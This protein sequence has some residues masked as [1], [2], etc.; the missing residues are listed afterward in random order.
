MIKK[1]FIN[2]ILEMFKRK[3]E[4]DFSNGV[5]CSLKVNGYSLCGKEQS[6]SM[7]SLISIGRS[8]NGIRANAYSIELN[9]RKNKRVA[10]LIDDERYFSS[11]GIG[12]NS[13]QILAMLKKL[14]NEIYSIV[15]VF[16]PNTDYLTDEI[17][18][19]AQSMIA[20]YNVVHIAIYAQD[21]PVIE[22]QPYL[23]RGFNVLLVNGVEFYDCREKN[24]ILHS[25]TGASI[26]TNLRYP[27]K[28]KLNSEWIDG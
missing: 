7:A 15:T 3:E 22:A 12:L 10:Y 6:F 4:Y 24:S 20:R 28:E 16:L 5:E 1:L 2:P 23:S 13:E 18:N 11:N 8:G 27:D 26:K 21:N 25:I 14:E 17:L 19:L 9:A